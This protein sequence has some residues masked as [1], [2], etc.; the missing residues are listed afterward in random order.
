M[1]YKKVSLP[2]LSDYSANTRGREE[3]VD[4]PQSE[5]SVSGFR[6]RTQIITKK[7]LMV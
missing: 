2:I 1:V 7:T 5:H 4:R 6:L 3:G